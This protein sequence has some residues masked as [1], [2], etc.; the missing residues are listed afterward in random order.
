MG[1]VPS[2]TATVL[3][4]LSAP[5]PSKRGL[6]PHPAASPLLV[7]TAMPGHSAF[8][9]GAQGIGTAFTAS[10]EHSLKTGTQLL[11]LL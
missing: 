6:S 4:V 1:R 3:G 2:P 5:H 9:Q 10:G 8:P 11:L 7:G